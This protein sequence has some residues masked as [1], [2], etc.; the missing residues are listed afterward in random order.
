M[1]P[2]YLAPLA[3]HLWQST[4]FAAAAGLLTLAL[5]NNPARVRHWVWIAASYKFL[6]PLAVLIAL[7]GQV[8][9]QKAPEITV[10]NIAVVMD[11]VSQP[12]A[13]RTVPVT[14]P[15]AEPAI[16]PWTAILLAVWACGFLGIALAWWVRWRRIR[17]AV[18]AGSA[19]ELAVPIG[20]VSSPTLLEPGIFGV[21]RPVLVLPE[22]ILE[23]LTPAQLEAVIE[24]ELCHVRHRDNLTAAIQ[25]LVETI[26]WFHPLV[27]WMGKRMVEERERACDE[28]VLQR[29]SAPRDYAEGNSENLEALCGVAAR[30]CARGN[31]SGPEEQRFRRYWTS[32]LW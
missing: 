7:G 13:S 6:I 27:W 9:W 25:M 20:V 30:V 14:L 22:G 4:V 2:A 28:E 17:A 24:H 12:F 32:G 16:S 29:G 19:L 1:N 5:R 3:N 31:R 11:T 21:C 15:V 18:C 8:Q 23:K 10:S 26:F